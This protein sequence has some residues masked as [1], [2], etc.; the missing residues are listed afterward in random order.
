MVM[1]RETAVAEQR[2]RGGTTA[3]K[4]NWEAAEERVSQFVGDLAN[5]LQTE[6]IRLKK[7]G[8]LHSEISAESTLDVCTLSKVYTGVSQWYN[9]LDA[10]LIAAGCLGVD[11]PPLDPHATV[12]VEEVYH[13]ERGNIHTMTPERRRAVVENRLERFREALV[14]QIRAHVQQD[15][16]TPA[17]LN[18]D[19][20]LPADLLGR[21]CRAR[22]PPQGVVVKTERLLALCYLLKRP[23]GNIRIK[24]V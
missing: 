24:V 3:A 22:V 21:V 6:L 5:S 8:F 12:V 17:L 9:S 2:E 20:E 18:A 7:D 10:L 14:L 13:G 19:L 1:K 16:R 11:H 4:M 15:G 23:I